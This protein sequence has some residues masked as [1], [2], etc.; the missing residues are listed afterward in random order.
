MDNESIASIS[1]S[2][3]SATMD[4]QREVTLNITGMTCTSCSSKVEAAVSGRAGIAF[5]TVDHS[6]GRGRVRY[7]P[8]VVA[9]DIIREYVI[10]AG[11]GASFDM[12]EEEKG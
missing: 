5:V 6:S 1:R 9:P 2:D 4:T 11:F 7:D 8:S 10:E 12:P 3:D